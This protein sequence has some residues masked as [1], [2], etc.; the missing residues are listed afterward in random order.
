MT[1]ELPDMDNSGKN[2]PLLQRQCYIGY[3]FHQH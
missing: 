3:K 1:G 2:D